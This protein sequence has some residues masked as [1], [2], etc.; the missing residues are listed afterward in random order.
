MA[1]ASFPRANICE[2]C[3]LSP[4]LLLGLHCSIQ[5]RKLSQKALCQ[6]ASLCETLSR[7]LVLA[8]IMLSALSRRLGRQ[9]P[10]DPHAG[11]GSEPSSTLEMRIYPDHNT[12]IEATAVPNNAGPSPR[13]EGPTLPR[14]L[15][16]ALTNE[17]QERRARERGVESLSPAGMG[18]GGFRASAHSGA[19][20]H[21]SRANAAA[22]APFS[23]L[24][25]ASAGSPAASFPLSS[26]FAAVAH[27]LHAEGTERAQRATARK[28]RR[29]RRL[30]EE[31]SHL[32][33]PIIPSGAGLPSELPTH[34]LTGDGC[35][36]D[37]AR[38]GLVPGLHV[39]AEPA[40]YSPSAQ[41]P[42]LEALDASGDVSPDGLPGQL[43]YD[44]LLKWIEQLRLH[45][46]SI[47]SV[48]P[49]PPRLQPK[50]SLDSSASPTYPARSLNDQS[51]VEGGERLCSTTKPSKP[52]FCTSLQSYVNLKRNSLLLRP[53]SED[54]EGTAMG[55]QLGPPPSHALSFELDSAAAWASID[56]FICAP[57]RHG[58]MSVGGDQ[59]IQAFNQAQKQ[60]TPPIEGKS[61]PSGGKFFAEA[62]AAP[63]H[64]S[65]GYRV[66]TTRVARTFDQKIVLALPLSLR[67]FVPSYLE[68]GVSPAILGEATEEVD[69]LPQGKSDPHEGKDAQDH[70]FGLSS[71]LSPRSPLNNPF[72]AEPSSPA[73]DYEPILTS[74]APGGA[75]TA[76]D[77][78]P[79]FPSPEHPRL[80]LD[81]AT[82]TERAKVEKDLRETLKVAIVV[83]ALCEDGT[84]CPPVVLQLF[85]FGG[86]KFSSTLSNFSRLRSVH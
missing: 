85:L 6:L 28:R 38:N 61:S 27:A 16:R 30:R 65:L 54:D 21:G 53:W 42:G 32:F 73:L 3:I 17:I 68:Q 4:A 64:P 80:N 37:S 56:V 60:D 49:P 46:Q 1:S 19:P 51:Q 25:R 33:G 43:R 50:S 55:T 20:R 24:T 12:D 76:Q 71:P 48:S 77:V 22:E 81:P 72:D 18:V 70:K 45:E 39:S 15:P 84:S 13:S 31:K 2:C 40:R 29:Q 86:Q 74:Q 10:S 59:V 78:A 57:H 75:S 63:D 36:F 35:G 58:S 41:H 62:G 66:V 44:T 8:T 7:S 47:A 69:I 9:P 79:A 67:F 23:R 52:M 11:G 5:P 83:R 34:V 14:Y 26:P 82:S